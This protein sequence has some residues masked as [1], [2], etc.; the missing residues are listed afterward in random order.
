MSSPPP[1]TTPSAPPPA[2]SIVATMAGSPVAATSAGS[3]A[4]APVLYP[5]E[6]MS[7]VINDLVTAVQGIRLFLIGSRGPPTPSQSA[8][9][10]VPAPAPW[11]PPFTGVSLLPPPASV[12]PWAQWP[13]SA[14]ARPSATAT[15]GIPIHQIRFPL[16]PSLLPAWLA[17]PST[18]PVY[19]TTGEPPVPSLSGAAPGGGMH[20]PMRR[21]PTRTAPAG[22]HSHRPATPRSTSPPT[23]GRRTP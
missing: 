16:S 9:F 5:P 22:L 18:Q 21:A 11:A 15:G 2:P 4:L 14:P 13:P 8:A 12:Q 6:Q 23:M 19:T 3:A 7:G 10:S 17:A 1:T 20:A